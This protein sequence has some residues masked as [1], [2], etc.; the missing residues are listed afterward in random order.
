MKLTIDNI[1]GIAY[2]PNA[3]KSCTQEDESTVGMYV[4]RVYVTRRRTGTTI[5]A[6]A[7]FVLTVFLPHSSISPKSIS[8]FIV[9]SL[10]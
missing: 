4:G 7:F 5:F 8:Q 2:S 10:I 3:T 9:C 1:I 6:A